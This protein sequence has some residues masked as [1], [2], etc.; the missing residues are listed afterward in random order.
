MDG[1]NGTYM[2]PPN[3]EGIYDFP[4][5]N[6]LNSNQNNIPQPTTIYD[7]LKKN[8]NYIPPILTTNNQYIPHVESNIYSPPQNSVGFSS[9]SNNIYSSFQSNNQGLVNQTSGNI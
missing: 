4:T 7:D 3:E 8:P 6:Q 2:N 9:E 5:Q 1:Q